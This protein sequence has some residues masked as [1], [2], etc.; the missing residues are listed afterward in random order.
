[1]STFF[2]ASSCSLFGFGCEHAFSS[3]WRSL[4]AGTWTRDK[5]EHWQM[6]GFSGTFFLC[7]PQPKDNGWYRWKKKKSGRTDITRLASTSITI[8]DAL[9]GKSFEEWKNEKHRVFKLNSFFVCAQSGFLIFISFAETVATGFSHR[10]VE[11]MKCVLFNK[12]KN[13]WCAFRSSQ[14]SGAVWR[15]EKWRNCWELKIT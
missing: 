8:K 12:F 7:F 6:F 13:E 1:M 10:C 9:S 11:G 4:K 14:H 3:N 15:N 2:S 5:E